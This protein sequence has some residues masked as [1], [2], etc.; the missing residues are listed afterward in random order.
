MQ[1][2]THTVSPE[3]REAYFHAYDVFLG[4]YY[5]P[6]RNFTHSQRASIGNSLLA[7][8]QETPPELIEALGSLRHKDD[9]VVIKGFTPKPYDPLY[10]CRLGYATNQL[11]PI[12]AGFEPPPLSGEAFSNG[13]LKIRATSQCS[14]DQILHH[15]L[16]GMFY[17]NSL[18]AV[19]SGSRPC[20]TQFVDLSTAL[21]NP[22]F[23][24][25]LSFSSELLEGKDFSYLDQI[26]RELRTKIRD[27]L[28]KKRHEIG[29]SVLLATGSAVFFPDDRVLH[30]RLSHDNT[31][32]KFS[33]FEATRGVRE[34][35]HSVYDQNSTGLNALSRL[36]K[37]AKELKVR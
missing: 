10:D 22:N 15:D 3:M 9:L 37:E 5:G 20:A 8:E 23:V 18:T 32:E 1:V 6:V 30:G 33:G 11:L 34:L 16:K 25:A 28:E 19:N 17:I 29:H 31:L 21:H 14:S 24:K 13:K 4:N 27:L 36:H 35:L 26:E 2:Y 12:F 7:A